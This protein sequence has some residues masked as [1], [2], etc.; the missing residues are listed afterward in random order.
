MYLYS[1]FGTCVVLFVFFASQAMWQP[2]LRPNNGVDPVLAKDSMG[3]NMGMPPMTNQRA[4]A[5]PT[6]SIDPHMQQNMGIV[7]GNV[8]KGPVVKCIRTVGTI[9]YD[10]T[11]LYNITTKFQGWVEKL[12]VNT[13]GQH[14]M[15]GEPLF[16]IYSPELY[17]AQEEYLVSIGTEL[18]Q[19]A[20]K[21]L[22]YFDVPVEEIQKLQES[23]IKKALTMLS[24]VDGIVVE[25]NVIQ[26][27]MVGSSTA[28]YRIADISKVWLQAEIYEQDLPFA[29][30]GQEVTIIVPYFSDQ[31]FSGRIS[32]I[33]PY[34]TPKTRTATARIE[35]TNS[36]L[37]LKPDMYATVEIAATLHE[38][39][40]LI[41][42]SAVLRSGSKNTVFVAL[43]NGYF[44]PRE[45]RLG[46]YAANNMYEILN[47]LDEKDRIVLSGQF[48]LDSESQLQNA[49]LKMGK[50]DTAHH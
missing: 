6:I 15:K 16:T 34:V 9:A 50:N 26:G 48:L 31:K 45:V 10:E 35:L 49:F 44:E 5:M 2:S 41:P 27:Q 39:G 28:S 33:Y 8:T 30:V 17:A 19:S 14:V 12:Y 29:A 21:K 1:I 42:A 4:S 18:Q 32:F 3:M 13:T 43:G 11:T 22:Q 25:K 40:L 47:G 37:L 46:P 23:G 20:L 38:E 36:P 7:L 24:P